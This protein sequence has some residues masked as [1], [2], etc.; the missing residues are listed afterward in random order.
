MLQANHNEHHAPGGCSVR[1]YFR[2]HTFRQQLTILSSMYAGYGAMMIS[3]Q[4]VTILSP[5]LLADES[6]NFTVKDTGDILAYGTIGAMVG[7]LIWGPL[8][9]KIGGRLTFLIL[10]R[11][12]G[13]S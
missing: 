10:A 6:L 7:K 2:D 3:R 12:R 8:A 1:D 5:A 13:S 4:M 9:D 11:E